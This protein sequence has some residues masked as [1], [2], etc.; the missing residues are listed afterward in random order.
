MNP[1]D[2]VN[3]M[4]VVV[5]I[6]G[7]LAAATDATTAEQ[8]AQS[9]TTALATSLATRLK[10]SMRAEGV[11]A[12]IDTCHVDAPILTAEVSELQGLEVGRTALRV[13]N[14][15][16]APDSWEIEQL[17]HF[18]SALEAGA[19]PSSLSALQRLETMD[20][21]PVWR[22]MR[23][24]ITGGLCLQCHG[25][26]VTPEVAAAIKDRYPNDEAM[27]FMLG[28]LRGAFTVTVLD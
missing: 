24:I 15:N 9:A 10:A 20:G 13:R 26:R 2:I 16:N 1:K 25:T 19:N 3:I 8:R 11:L 28:E 21:Q 12:A 18:K 7:P 14:P 6:S 17:E 4:G 22:Y 27:N 5:A 23:P